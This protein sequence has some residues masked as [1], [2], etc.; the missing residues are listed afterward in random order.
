M[1]RIKAVVLE[2]FQ[3]VSF[4]LASENLE[5]KNDDSRKINIKKMY[6]KN[7]IKL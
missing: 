4:G 5:I 3:S 7:K 6:L 2:L 1:C